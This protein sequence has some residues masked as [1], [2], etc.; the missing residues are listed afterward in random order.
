MN[1]NKKKHVKKYYTFILGIWKLA[2][3]VLSKFTGP[4]EIKFYNKSNISF[5]KRA[6]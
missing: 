1:N 5:D 4:G 3:T 6:T 2:S